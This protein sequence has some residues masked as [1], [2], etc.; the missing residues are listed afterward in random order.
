MP[1][2]KGKKYGIEKW[3]GTSESVNFKNW[4]ENS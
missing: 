3:R 1:V 4:L 2:P